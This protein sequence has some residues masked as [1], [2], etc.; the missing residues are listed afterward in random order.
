[1]DDDFNTPGALSSLF[2]LV[3]S[4]NQ[5]RDSGASDD[6]LNQAQGTLKELAGVLGLNLAEKQLKSQDVVPFVEL[7]ITI[8]KEL[9]EAEQWVLADRVR[10]G[11][12]DLG[13]IIE[14]S[15]SGTTWR[16]E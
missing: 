9:R 16:Y 12:E 15:K 14:D 1:M 5:A 13:I 11:L 10:D 3:R 2:D 8:R 7:L 6:D 4:I